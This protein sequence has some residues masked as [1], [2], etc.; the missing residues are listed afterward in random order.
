MD[1][2]LLM[3]SEIAFVLLILVAV[4]VL[5]ATEIVP[6]E[7]T[8]L[9]LVVLLAGTGLITAEEALR[10]FA[11]ESIAALACVMVLSQRL[12]DSGVL[13]GLSTR[14]VGQV[15]T[16]PSVISARLM[17]STAALSMI[18]SNT[19]TAAVMMPV[20]MAAA[21]R[22]KL[23]PARFLMPMAFASIM[24]GSATLIGTSTNMAV[25]GAV[26]RAGLEP[27]NLFEFFWVG[28]PVAF[29]G[30]ATMLLL[31]ERIVRAEGAAETTDEE[32]DLFL[33]GLTIPVSSKADATALGALGLR[34]LGATPVAIDT[35]DGRLA[36]HPNRNVHEGDRIILHAPGPVLTALLDDPRFEVDGTEE[37]NEHRIAAEAILLPGS[38]WIGMSVARMRHKLSPDISVLGLKR[39]GYERAA[40]T[41]RMRLKAGDILYLIGNDEGMNRIDA[42]V[43]MFILH[44]TEPVAPGR[45]EGWY[46]LCALILALAVS[47]ANLLPLSVALLTAVLGLVLAGRFT[48]R[49]AFGMVS[50]P[51]LI[52]IGGMSSFGLAMLET[53]AAD[54]LAGGI[55]RYVAP[56]GLTAVLITLALVT[57]ILTQPLS[58]AAAALTVLPVAIALANNLGVDPRSMAVI[59]ALS[60]SLS[61][62]APLEPA[63]LLVY[64]KA[65]Y[66]LWDFVR[67]GAPLTAVSLVIV[68]F[69][70]PRI[71]PL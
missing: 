21:R 40:T 32:S 68:L 39:S 57:V 6:P 59:V 1:V 49:D 23:D 10:G 4:F 48:L 61:F 27:F 12:S 28:L 25:N 56:F 29:A 19:S 13:I 36:A 2:P 3:S 58:N 41:G 16:L 50:W 9:G 63:L 20:A 66:R 8:A 60:A 44:E 11:S 30:I 65:N 37:G 62:I 55:L 67:V 26:I 70:V 45:Q 33:A 18:F 64:G 14:L 34:E 42:D 54:W 31:G 71:W 5:L 69:L 17:G 38:R 22:A 53:G 24:G 47:A 52:L 35:A 7:V 46:T 15:K 51:V 43:D